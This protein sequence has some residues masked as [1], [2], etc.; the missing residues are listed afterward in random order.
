VGPPIPVE[1]KEEPTEED[2]TAL[3]KLYL[4]TLQS[5]YATHSSRYGYGGK[6][7]IVI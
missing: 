1:K 2:V 3:A 4:D 6:P 5:L 7:L